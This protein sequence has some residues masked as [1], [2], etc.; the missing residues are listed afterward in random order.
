MSQVNICVII[1]VLFGGC[2]GA[3]D[4]ET[5]GS[6]ADSGVDLR[7]RRIARRGSSAQRLH[8]FEGMGI[9]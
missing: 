4:Q 7:L 1:W 2:A 6:D 3:M 8:T 9:G 5:G